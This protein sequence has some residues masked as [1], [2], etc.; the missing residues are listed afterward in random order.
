MGDQTMNQRSDADPSS[1]GDDATKESLET[2]NRQLRAEVTALR[3]A[4]AAR[5]ATTT[6]VSAREIALEAA[7]L[8]LPVGVAVFD[9]EDRLVVKNNRFQLFDSK[10]KRDRPGTPFEDILKFAVEL[11]LA[12]EAREDPEGWIRD[13]LRKRKEP[14]PATVQGLSD[15]RFIQIEERRLEDG[16]LISAYTDVTQLKKTEAALSRALEQSEAAG[17]S[18]T[19]FLAKMSHELR[20]PLNA[21]IGFCQMM[22]EDKESRIPEE[23]RRGYLADIQFAAGHLHDLISDIL[24][25]ARIE[26]G[27]EKLERR[28]V[29][30]VDLCE[31]VAKMFEP[32]AKAN[33]INLTFA[34]IDENETSAVR[35]VDD[36]LV[37]QM[38]INLLTNSMRFAPESGFVT[39]KLALSDD[40]TTVSVTDNGA[41]VS[42]EDLKIIMEPFQQGSTKAARGQGGVGLGLSLT[43]GMAELHGGAI[44]IESALGE[45]TTVTLRLPMRLANDPMPSAP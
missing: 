10:G 41:G 30:V 21:I 7:L 32:D 44:T 6:E 9:P 34:R 27:Q 45:G 23:R 29:D 33:A 19:Q 13:R 38:L 5:E 17:R 35:L 3:Q 1:V 40:E 11:G 24:E 20:T 8:A 39:L 4:I 25:L 26:S 42:P 12:A 18:K 14:G 37:T 2:E 36:R 22:I 15:G 28:L 31:R 43:K 16:G